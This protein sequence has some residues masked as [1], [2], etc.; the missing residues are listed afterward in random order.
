MRKKLLLVV[1]AVTACA[2]SSQRSS[3]D[4]TVVSRAAPVITSVRVNQA[5]YGMSSKVKWML[6]GD[7]ASILAVVDPVGV[8]AEPIPNSFFY[9]SETKN[10]QARM[11]SVWDVAVSPDWNTIAFSRAFVMSAGG[12]DSI[13]ASMFINVARKAGLDTATVRTA[14]FPSSGMTM[15]RAIAQAGTIQVP[16]DAR[17]TGASDDAAPKMYPVAVGWRV[18]WTS[19]GSLIALGNSPASATD[20][21]ASETWAS[22]DP[23]TGAFHTSLPAGSGPAAP[24]WINGPTLEM[25]SPV[26]LQGAPSINIA[27]GGRKLAIESARGVITAREAGIVPDSSARTYTIGSGKAL[28]ATKGGRYILALAPRAKAVVGEM[29]A[30]VLVYVVGW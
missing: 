4:S 5:T 30:E 1:A 26:D 23:K 22:L 8:E 25:A 27:P 28:A 19:D 7:S 18:R 17:A 24:K 10:F 6:S 2:E 9:G 3:A 16:A 20:D 14:S 29:P 13:P 11:D 21:A 12:E 15:S